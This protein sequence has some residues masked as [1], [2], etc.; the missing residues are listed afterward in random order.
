MQRTIHYLLYSWMLLVQMA[1]A[2]DHA[3][4][5]PSF[6]VKPELYATGFEFAEGPAFDNAGN[7]YVVNYRGFGNIGRITREGQASVWCDLTKLAPSEDRKPQANGLKVDGEGWVIAADAGAGRLLRISPDAA[8]VDV[9]AD[10]FQGTRFNS[11]NDVAIAGIGIY[12]TDPGR[13]SEDNPVGSVYRFDVRSRAVSQLATGLA[14]PNGLA[15]TPDGK[16]LCV[17][18]S[19]KFRVLIFDLKTDGGLANQRVLID[20]PPQDRGAIR[21]GRFD[22]DGMVFDDKGRLYVAMWTGGFINVVEVP[23]GELLRQYDAGGSKVT[24]CHFFEDS[25]FVTVAANEAVFRLK[26]GVQGFNYR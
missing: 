18:E 10:R 3:D 9:L 2:A 4:L 23:S 22:P 6:S 11:L 5:P 12:F 16:H 1:S 8:K 25:L 26:L 17:G 20:F 24:N 7:L 15:V 13:S 19:R 14:Y 21:G